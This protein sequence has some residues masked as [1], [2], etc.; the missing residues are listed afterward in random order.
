MRAFNESE[1]FNDSSIDELVWKWKIGLRKGRDGGDI[2]SRSQHQND[3]HPFLIR[4]GSYCFVCAQHVG[5]LPEPLGSSAQVAN[6]STSR[7]RTHPIGN[8]TYL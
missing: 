3:H 1:Y 5:A 8:R 7:Y 4:K 6:R 2:N